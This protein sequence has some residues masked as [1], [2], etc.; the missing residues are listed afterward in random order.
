M[1]CYEQD[2]Q[3]HKERGIEPTILTGDEVGGHQER[4]KA[5][6]N[7]RGWMIDS[8]KKRPSACHTKGRHSS[9]VSLGDVQHISPMVDRQDDLTLTSIALPSA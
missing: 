5:D 2:D 6:A 3:P 9:E 8:G 4:S 7:A 1:W